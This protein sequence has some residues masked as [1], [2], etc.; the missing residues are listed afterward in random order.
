MDEGDKRVQVA[1]MRQI[2][3]EHKMEE[4]LKGPGKLKT[5]E[6]V[7]KFRME[8][9]IEYKGKGIDEVL[10]N[11]KL[12]RAEI[13]LNQSWDTVRF[14]LLHG[15]VSGGLQSVI[16]K[17]WDL[18]D[19]PVNYMLV[20][21]VANLG[22]ALVRGA[23]W[24][25]GWE[26][27]LG[28]A[29]FTRITESEGGYEEFGKG[30]G[31][32]AET[33]PKPIKEYNP[34]KGEVETKEKVVTFRE[35]KFSDQRPLFGQAIGE[36]FRL[37]AI[38]YGRNA[39]SFGRPYLY[40]PED[41][42]NITSLD[43]VNYVGR[44]RYFSNLGITSALAYSAGG[45]HIG[46]ATTN[47]KTSVS[48]I[49]GLRG[50][51]SVQPQRLVATNAP[52]MQFTIQTLGYESSLDHIQTTSFVPFDRIYIKASTDAGEIIRNIMSEQMR[53]EGESL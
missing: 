20:S 47:V 43:W 40:K 9:E 41:V 23:V 36:S 42:K 33:G 27:S 32:K 1:M 51:F 18:E 4:H 7:T 28:W 49:R 25:A 26:N 14:G 22:S 31:L 50:I 15:L 53:V 38:D 19:S 8:L 48:H 24:Y 17:N 34:E 3:F 16:A 45:A 11:A 44:L 30:T 13:V 52:K 37:A 29:P 6:D 12:T 2:A 46:A 39:F 35:I 5:P 21:S 10:K